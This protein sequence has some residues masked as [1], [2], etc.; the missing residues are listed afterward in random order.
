MTFPYPDPVIYLSQLALQCLS[1]A[2][3]ATEAQAASGAGGV[4]PFVWKAPTETCFRVSTQIPF[5][6]DKYQDMCCEGL[7]YVAIGGTW[8]STGSF[9][10]QDVVRQAQSHCSP[11]A[12]AQEIRMGLVRCIPVG[13]QGIGAQEFGMPT[14]SEWTEAAY[15]NMWDS[16]C[17][18]KA[19]CCF[20]TRALAVPFF[21]GMSFIFDRQVQGPPLGGCVERYVNLQAQF[22]N[23]DC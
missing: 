19:T 21:D 5:D 11:P 9:P 1:E 10:E 15:T 17:L 16:I 13:T 12:W 20:R 18:R 4:D 7:G 22:P 6:M 23:C 3:S 14:C 2:I 8:P